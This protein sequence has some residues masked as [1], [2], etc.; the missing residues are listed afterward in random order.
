LPG[1]YDVKGYRENPDR[2]AGIRLSSTG[3]L[4]LAS[5]GLAN[6]KGRVKVF[7]PAIARAQAA[8]CEKPA[9]V[10]QKTICGDA[11]LKALD[12]K[13]VVL[14]AAA[15]KDATP[16]QKKEIETQH[17]RW[18]AERDACAKDADVKKCV[19]DCYAR[20]NELLTSYASKASAPPTRR[21]VSYVCA[22]KSKL[23]VEYVLGPKEHVLVAH[24]AS[25][26]TLPHVPSGSGARYEEGTVSLWNKGKEVTLE[27]AGK[28]L[29]CAESK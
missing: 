21:S 4:Q 19:D 17:G 10:V 1:A 23:V 26:W 25:K 9:N 15:T 11:D 20:R 8:D 14:Y 7:Q 29:V 5:L 12:A 6:Q 22:D 18:A 2:A 28:L 16:A 3:S 24:G 27:Q 13:M